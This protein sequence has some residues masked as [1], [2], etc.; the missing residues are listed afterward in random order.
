M[1]PRCWLDVLNSRSY[2]SHKALEIITLSPWG[3]LIVK[4][5]GFWVA[6]YCSTSQLSY[7]M[8]YLVEER[9]PNWCA[10]GSTKLLMDCW[11]ASLVERFSSLWGVI[12]CCQENA[13]D[14]IVCAYL[15]A[16][17]G[18]WYWNGVSFTEC[19]ND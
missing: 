4:F 3:P 14:R 19:F 2:G 11:L 7:V 18:R 5:G 6:K 13:T 1:I 15:Q 9:R 8:L 12:C 17:R 10:I 16:S